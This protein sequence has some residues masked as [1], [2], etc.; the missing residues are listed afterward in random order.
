MTAYAI[1]RCED[2]ARAA[3]ILALT[4]AAFASL[5]I[6]PPSSVLKETVAD[7]SRRISAET[8]LHYLS[9]TSEEVWGFL[10]QPGIFP[11]PKRE[12]NTI[13]GEN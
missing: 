6:D 13:E 10:K 7:F 5:P 12:S 9:F 2:P 3:E 8:C 1:R 11:F 4:H